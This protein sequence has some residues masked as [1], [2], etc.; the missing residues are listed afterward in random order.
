MVL[1]W[2]AFASSLCLHPH[3]P[4]AQHTSEKPARRASRGTRDSRKALVLQGSFHSRR[5]Q[6]RWDSLAVK[7]DGERETGLQICQELAAAANELHIKPQISQSIWLPAAEWT[8]PNCGV[9][10]LY[11]SCFSYFWPPSFL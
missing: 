7:R 11:A 9:H 10:A 8:Q 5:E 4:T 1:C 2:V 3:I 6:M